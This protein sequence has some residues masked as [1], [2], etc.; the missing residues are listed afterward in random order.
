M[1]VFTIVIE[2]MLKLNGT[3]KK[4]NALGVVIKKKDIIYSNRMPI[5]GPKF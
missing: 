2:K 5:M 4:N 1:F 3:N